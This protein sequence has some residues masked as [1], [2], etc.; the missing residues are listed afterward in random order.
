MLIFGVPRG[1][2]CSALRKISL[3][4]GLVRIEVDDALKISEQT[5]I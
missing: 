1:R 5:E 2:L 3:A 4:P